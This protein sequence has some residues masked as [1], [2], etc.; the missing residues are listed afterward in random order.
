MRAKDYNE[1]KARLKILRQKAAERNPDEFHYGMLNSRS[2]KG[3]KLADRGNLSMSQDAVKLLKTQDSG[4]L[5]VMIQKT[6]R[7]IQR[8]EQEFTLG[9]GNNVDVV[10][11]REPAEKRQHLIY[12]N[13][14]EEQRHYDYETTVEGHTD[15]QKTLKP[16]GGDET[17]NVECNGHD[18]KPMPPGRNDEKGVAAS[19]GLVFPK[20][21][22]KQQAARK[23]KLAT[24]KAREKSLRDAENNLEIQRAKMSNSMGGVTKN[25]VKWKARE[26]KS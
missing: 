4:Y 17:R 21:Y 2:K 26:R 16:E 20:S 11:E 15:Q 22:Q 1:K 13:D 23:T 24:L 12:V 5:Q 7:S 25:G 3:M 14:A 10:G 8:L 9:H 19:G 18:A 6:R